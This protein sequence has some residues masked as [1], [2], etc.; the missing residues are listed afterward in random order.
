M[1]ASNDLAPNDHTPIDLAP[2]DLAPIDLTPIDLT[3]PIADH[4]RWPVERRLVA[5]HGKGDLFQVTWQGF[6]VHGFTHMDSPRHYFP[7]GKTTDDIGLEQTVGSAAVID[8]FGI[9]PMTA[10]DAEMLDANGAHVVSGEIVVFRTGWGERRSASTPDFWLDAPYLERSA[11]Q[12][13]L[14]RS[15]KAVAFDFPQ[16]YCIRLLLSGEIRPIEEHVSHDVLLRNDV[17][18][19]EYLT[20]TRALTTARI[21]FCCLPLKLPD[22]DGAPARVVAWLN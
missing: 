6:A 2:I 4:F 8:L 5:D 17:V 9:E 11:A 20:N 22:S 7:D 19:I 3:M 16:D 14:A 1:P 10:I 13:L 15:P 12:W 21:S 18:L